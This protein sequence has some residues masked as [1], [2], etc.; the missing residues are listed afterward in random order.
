MKRRVFILIVISIFFLR[1]DAQERELFR[2]FKLKKATQ[3]V[4]TSLYNKIRLIDLRKDTLRVGVIQ[5]GMLNKPF[6]LI[7]KPS[8]SFQLAE[9]IN[10]ATS[11]NTN[12]KQGELVFCLRKLMFSERTAA[13]TE[14]GFCAFNADFYEKRDSSYFFIQSIDTVVRVTGYDVT[15]ALL[16][17]GDSI[18]SKSILS[19]LTQHGNRDI[20]LSY[21]EIIYADSIA[22]HKIKIYNTTTFTDGVYLTYES[23]KNQIPDYREVLVDKRK[24]KIKSVKRSDKNGAIQ[25]LSYNDMYALV[26]DGQP[27]IATGFGFYPLKFKNNEFSFIGKLKAPAKGGSI[28]PTMLVFGLMGGLIASEIKNSSYFLTI[29]NYKNG[30]FIRVREIPFGVDNDQSSGI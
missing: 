29:I 26:I 17:S 5:L 22:K 9:F 25:K 3:V 27:Y 11:E 14:E 24:E 4:T 10:S 7:L 1:I 28:E 20:A 21:N 12:L 6:T 18:I 15:K 13:F 8:F 19:N 23:F 30:E 16:R 2:E